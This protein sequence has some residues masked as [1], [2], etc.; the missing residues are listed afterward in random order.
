MS[1]GKVSVKDTNITTNRPWGNLGTPKSAPKY[2]PLPPPASY[3]MGSVPDTGWYTAQLPVNSAA[4]VAQPRVEVDIEG[5][6]FYEQQNIIY[7]VHV[8]SDANIKTLKA[9][10]PRTEGAALEQLDGPVLSTRRSGR[11]N[12]QQIIN[13]YRYKLMP[14]RSGEIT[15]PAI[16]FT[17]TWAQSRQLPRGPGIPASIPA[18]SFSIAAESARTLQVLKANTE[19]NPWLPLHDLKLETSLLQKGAAKAGEPVTLIV[20]LNAIGALGNQLPSLTQQLESEHYRIYRDATEI[21]NAVSANGHYLIGTRKETYTVIPLEDGRIQLPNV[22]L[23]W[24]DVDTHSARLAGLPHTGKSA[25]AT[26]AAALTSGENSMFPVYFWAPLV[27]TLALLAGFWLGAW[28]RTRPLL[29]TAAAWSSAL[30]QHAVKYA[31]RHA[32]RHAHRVGIRLSPEKYLKRLRMGLALLM[33]GSIKVWMC[34]R[35]LQAEDN[36]EAW[37]T[38][39]KNRVCQH[40]GISTHAP[41]TQITEKIIATSPQADPARLRAMAHSLDGA[42]YG[43]SSLD[44]PAW[45]RELVHQLRPRV[46]RQRR[47]RTRRMRSSLPALNPRA[48]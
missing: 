32:H 42:I 36:P 24:W 45:K 19:V 46:L 44:F 16:R 1:N 20:E 35:C 27:I 6:V 30:G 3:Y 28:H 34:T 7:T 17:G 12:K 37:C 23:A 4:T 39:F 14:L 48:A 13:S 5:A 9:E 47:S 25:A 26:R 2:Q 15:I 43:G 10:V 33:P 21:K 18:G 22:G 8:V 31:H 38:E 41:L 40:L 11:D 29:K